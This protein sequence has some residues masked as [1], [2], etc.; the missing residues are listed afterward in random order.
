[1]RPSHLPSTKSRL[2]HRIF[3][4][5]A[6]SALLAP[7]L[8]LLFRNPTLFERTDVLPIVVYVLVSFTFCL[9]SFG[10]FRLANSLPRFFSFHDSIEIGKRC[11]VHDRSENET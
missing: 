1:M 6:L 4:L 2:S 8:A 11:K 7:V 3:A 5:D 9:A 10:A